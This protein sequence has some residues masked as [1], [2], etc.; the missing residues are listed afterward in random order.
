MVKSIIAKA[1]AEQ[2]NIQQATKKTE[3]LNI[4]LLWV[5]AG[6]EAI[7]LAS[8]VLLAI[9]ISSE[10]DPN[11]YN[12]VALG[13]MLI[14]FGVLIGYYA[15]AIYFYNINLGLTNE[16]WAEIRERRIHEPE[17][18]E[19]VP[20]EN[21]NINQTLG[22]PT[23]TV[24][25]TVALTLLMGA[26]AMTIAALGMDSKVSANAFLVD[27]FDFFKTAFIMMIAFYFGNKSLEMLGYKTGGGN[28]E[29]TN[30]ENQKTD[31]SNSNPTDA[32]LPFNNPATNT[33][34]ILQNAGSKTGA[35]KQADRDGSPDFNQPDAVS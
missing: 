32:P 3:K 11:Y 5:F 21:P 23:G 18:A 4:I 7:L 8:L 35:D 15:W 30:S 20:N 33:K 10:D 34:K 25:G 31:S 1:M 24:R 27:N 2:N 16:D 28:N 14:W 6:L 22:L 12:L 9:Q 13:I 19:N 26:V 29:N 17:G